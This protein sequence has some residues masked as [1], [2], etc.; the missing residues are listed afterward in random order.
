MAAIW[1]VLGH[2]ALISNNDEWPEDIGE[3][4]PGS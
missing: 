2:S 3:S 1:V 4:N